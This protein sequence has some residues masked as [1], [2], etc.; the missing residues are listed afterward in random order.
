M[1]DG[2][3]TRDP[4][5]AAGH[6]GPR[7]THARGPSIYFPAYRDRSIRYREFDFAKR[8]AWGKFLETYLDR[9]PAG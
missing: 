6:V 1:T 2:Q 8:T 9:G 7:M 5:I 4:I 3:G